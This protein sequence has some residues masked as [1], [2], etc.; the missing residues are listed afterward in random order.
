M[1]LF[2]LVGFC[3]V[4]SGA[5]VIAREDEAIAPGANQLGGFSGI[6]G[7]VNNKLIANNAINSDAYFIANLINVVMP[8]IF[9]IAGLGLLIM[10]ITG[11]FQIMFAVSSPEGAESG[12]KRI[13]S[14]FVGLFILFSAYWLIQALEII[15]GFNLLG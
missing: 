15:F 1:F 2:V 3:L 12:K 13:T 10:L 5:H 14:A 7:E 8:Y 9:T 11:G 6:F 4:S